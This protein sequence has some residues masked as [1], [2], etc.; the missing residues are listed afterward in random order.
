M[1]LYAAQPFRFGV[2]RFLDANIAYAAGR[3]SQKQR[4]IGSAR[5]FNKAEVIGKLPPCMSL[6]QKIQKEGRPA[7]AISVFE[8]N[9]ITD[10]QRAMVADHL[11]G[12][13]FRRCHSDEIVEIVINDGRALKAGRVVLE[14]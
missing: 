9:G 3:G 2:G 8:V 6:G 4:E 10:G 1:A 7:A 13:E 12:R 14:F 11:S 5:A